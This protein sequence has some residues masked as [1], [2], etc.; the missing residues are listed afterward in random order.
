VRVRCGVCGFGV[1]MLGR[2][3][4]KVRGCIKWLQCPKCEWTFVH[5]LSMF[6]Y[7]KVMYNVIVGGKKKGWRKIV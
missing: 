1:M 5:L 3:G 7:L 4:G 2:V 6:R